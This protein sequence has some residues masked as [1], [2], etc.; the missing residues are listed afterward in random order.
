M[1]CANLKFCAVPGPGLSG[2]R[3]EGP[4]A[5]EAILM[6]GLDIHIQSVRMHK[7]LSRC[8][9]TDELSCSSSNA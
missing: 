4:G 7:S 9:R 2:S 1:N 8:L 5:R 6:C 3:G